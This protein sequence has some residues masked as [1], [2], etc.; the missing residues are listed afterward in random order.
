[1]HGQVLNRFGYFSFLRVLF[2]YRQTIDFGTPHVKFTPQNNYLTLQNKIVK[3]FIKQMWYFYQNLQYFE[4][5]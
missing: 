3:V 2:I 5:G 1:S 4:G